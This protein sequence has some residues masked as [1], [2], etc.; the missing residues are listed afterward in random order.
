MN[1]KLMGFILASALLFQA[2][3]ATQAPTGLD[4]YFCDLH[5]I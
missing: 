3:L 5:P 2:P 1:L 4:H